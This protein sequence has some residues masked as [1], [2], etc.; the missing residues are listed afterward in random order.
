MFLGSEQF[1]AKFSIAKIKSYGKTEY[2][3]CLFFS[4]LI[5]KLFTKHVETF[6]QKRMYFLVYKIWKPTF[7]IKER[8]KLLL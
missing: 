7:T 8:L 5:T 2:P 4:N 6:F 3:N 1:R